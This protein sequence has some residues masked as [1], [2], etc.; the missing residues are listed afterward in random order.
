M[1]VEGRPINGGT[2]V[3]T[4]VRPAGPVIVGLL[5]LLAFGLLFQAMFVWAGRQVDNMR[6]GFPR[7][8]Q[9]SG[10]VGHG[11]ERR[12]PSY[13]RT[14]NLDGQISVLVIPGGDT[15]QLQV[16]KGP[17]LVGNDGLYEVALPELRDVSGDGHVDLLV[18][19]RGEVVVYINENEEF[20]LMNDE[21]RTVLL[22]ESFEEEQ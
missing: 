12:M 4:V 17:Y 3:I 18:T 7:S 9:I 8:V 16:L 10:Y 20:R 15:G 14:L 13:I 22:T 19:V 2:D 21:E 5:A 11:D 6:Y 1:A